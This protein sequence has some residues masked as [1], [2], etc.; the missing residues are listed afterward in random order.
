VSTPLVELDGVSRW[1]GEVIALNAVTVRIGSGVI[2]LLG[3]NGAGKTTLLRL[4]TGQIRPSLGRVQVLGMDPFA[5]PELYRRIGVLPDTEALPE[6]STGSEFLETMAALHGMA[7]ARCRQRADE[8]IA[9]VGLAGEAARRRIGGYSKGMRQRLKLAQ[10]ILHEPELLFLDEPLSG[11]DPLA[12]HDVGTLLRGWV[13][14]GGS[15][16]V[17]SHILKEVEGMTRR[18]LLVLDGRI[19]AEGEL[20][21]I[22]EL[23]ESEPRR[24]AIQVSDPK[25]LAAELQ[26]LPQVVGLSFGDSGDSLVVRTRRASELFRELP[27]IALDKGLRI[28]E[29]RAEDEDLESVFGYLVKKP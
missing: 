25:A 12:R 2:G 21:E 22:R 6:R 15:V 26:R 29:I 16:L 8:A 17:S 9:A 19:R 28:H 1:Y 20:S 3:P 5:N 27:R 11:M 14:K 4:A 13:D 24:V 18:V 7:P 10:A 23:I